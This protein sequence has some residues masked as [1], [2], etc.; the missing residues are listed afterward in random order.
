MAL[1]ASINKSINPIS[2]E[3]LSKRQFKSTLTN[4]GFKLQNLLLDLTSPKSQLKSSEV[5][6]AV[7]SLLEPE[8]AVV[9]ASSS[10]SALE[11]TF[12]MISNMLSLNRSKNALKFAGSLGMLMIL[13][14]SM[15]CITLTIDIAVAGLAPPIAKVSTLMVV[16]AV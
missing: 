16:E 12:G 11:K 6:S 3:L 1:T 13:R 14:R 10:V 9:D 2:P 4:F 8:L 15:H 7:Y 5:D